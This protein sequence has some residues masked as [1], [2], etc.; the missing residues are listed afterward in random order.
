[1]FSCWHFTSCLNIGCFVSL[2]VFSNICLGHHL[3][4]WSCGTSHRQRELCVELAKQPWEWTS[5][6][7]MWMYRMKQNTVDPSLVTQQAVWN[8]DQL[9]RQW[10][11]SGI[12]KTK[13][14]TNNTER[15]WITKSLLLQDIFFAWKFDLKYTLNWCGYFGKTPSVL[16]LMEVIPYLHTST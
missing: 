6:I 15:V 13:A 8:L 2:S 5:T 11:V 10:E 16:R 1:M 4:F 7:V 12:E 9:L 3:L 14:K